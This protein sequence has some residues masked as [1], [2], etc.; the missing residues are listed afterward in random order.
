[1]LRMRHI[2]PLISAV[3][4]VIVFVEV[5]DLVRCPDDAVSRHEIDA[6]PAITSDSAPILLEHTCGGLHDHDGRSQESSTIPHC[7][8]SFAFVST[9]ALPALGRPTEIR[10]AYP[11]SDASAT[12]REVLVPSPVPLA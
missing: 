11:F 5:T 4:A 2:A 8:C 9:A 6:S 3:L 1:M 7:L 12:E 10:I